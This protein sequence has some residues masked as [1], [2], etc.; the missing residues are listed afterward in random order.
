MVPSM[1]SG[2]STIPPSEM[3]RLTGREQEILW[4]SAQGKSY[5]EI[6]EVRGNN[7]MTIKNA[8]YGKQRKLGVWTWQELG[9]RA[10][11]SGL[12]DEDYL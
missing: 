6:A 11:H 9:V 10:A 4:M 8:V 5:A 7:P 1:G 12:L 3:D 2:P